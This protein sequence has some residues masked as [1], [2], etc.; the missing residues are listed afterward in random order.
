MAT[1]VL[2]AAAIAAALN[3]RMPPPRVAAVAARAP[4][5]RAVA[6][7]DPLDPQK[8]DLYQILGCDR[9]CNRERSRLTP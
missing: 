9:D 8:D 2:I 5:P 3:G 4:P 1:A 7:A 6:D